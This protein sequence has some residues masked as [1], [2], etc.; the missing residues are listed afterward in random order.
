MKEFKNALDEK[1]CEE[2]G[3]FAF[4]LFRGLLLTEEMKNVQSWTNFSWH[5]E[6]RQDSTV[7]VCYFLPRRF[8]VQITPRLK[9]LGLFP[10]HTEENLNDYLRLMAYVWTEGSW[11]NW[12]DDGS[13]KQALTVYLNRDWEPNDGGY[14]LY[15]ENKSQERRVIDPAFN[16]LVYN[17]EKEAHATTPVSTSKKLRITLQGFVNNEVI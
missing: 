2:V 13:H 16:T 4:H 9:E 10:D 11:I 8:T 3:D 7:V 14:F 12:H 1:F 5:E 6:I 15:V 17:D